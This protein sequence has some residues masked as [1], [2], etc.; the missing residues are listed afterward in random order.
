MDLTNYRRLI[1]R[2]EQNSDFKQKEIQLINLLRNITKCISQYQQKL[3]AKLTEEQKPNLRERQ[4]NNLRQF[5]QSQ[6]VFRLF[7]RL[8]KCIL[9][10]LIDRYLISIELEKSDNKLSVYDLYE[11]ANNSKFDSLTKFLKNFL[12]L[13]QNL[14]FKF[15]ENKWTESV[16]LILN[17]DRI[18]FDSDNFLQVFF[19]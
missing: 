16:E 14:N 8:A 15:D 19:Y 13:A 10:Y 17:N 12:K 11:T 5:Q 3:G 2:Y 6:H 18:K 9:A 4:R 7:L 1:T